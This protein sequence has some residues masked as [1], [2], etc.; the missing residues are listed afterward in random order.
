MSVTITAAN[1][2]GH[3]IEENLYKEVPTEAARAFLRL[4]SRK[5]D[6]STMAIFLSDDS[7][8][9]NFYGERISDIDPE[10]L[11]TMFRGLSDFSH[12]DRQIVLAFGIDILNRIFELGQLVRIS[13]GPAWNNHLAVVVTEGQLP[14]EP[15][16]N[17][18]HSN[19]AHA[20]KLLGHN[21]PTITEC[22]TYKAADLVSRET[23][24]NR[25]DHETNRLLQVAHYAIKQF[26]AEAT[27]IVG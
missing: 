17:A 19:A 16:M 12:D 20:F 23:A 11:K 27:V 24:V 1:D 4:L 22:V 21:L 9:F 18:C 2:Q 15:V 26:G 3:R 25:C 7:E 13:I 10:A 6:T 8:G 5:M 14:G